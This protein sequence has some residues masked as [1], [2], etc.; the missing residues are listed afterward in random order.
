MDSTAVYSITAK[1]SGLTVDFADGD[2]TAVT[3]PACANIPTPVGAVT[4]NPSTTYDSSV[5]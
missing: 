4:V 1:T 2:L 3:N 5:L